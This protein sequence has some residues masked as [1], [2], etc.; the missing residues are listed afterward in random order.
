MI[1][2]KTIDKLYPNIITL[3]KQ[4]DTAIIG[5]NKVGGKSRL[6]Y[7]GNIVLEIIKEVKGVSKEL[8]LEIFSFTIEEDS[9]YG[10]L[11]HPLII[12]TNKHLI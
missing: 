6:V 7:D 1:T 3:H 8:A 5:I 10:G 2:R 11:T 4:Y 12:L 9:S